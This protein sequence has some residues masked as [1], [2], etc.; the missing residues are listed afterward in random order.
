MAPPAV[1]RQPE[2]GNLCAADS[3]TATLGN[4]TESVIWSAPEFKTV[5]L[6]L[7]LRSVRGRQMADARVPQL[8]LLPCT[9]SRRGRRSQPLGLRGTTCSGSWAS[10]T[11]ATR[12]A[13]SGG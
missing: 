5:T 4:G 9:S 8:K 7:T 2:P 1:G 13:L 11:S 3:G 12:M 6:L 10:V